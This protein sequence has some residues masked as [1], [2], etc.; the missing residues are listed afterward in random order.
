MKTIIVLLALLLLS[1]L[2]P[3]QTY[4]GQQNIISYGLMDSPENVFVSDLDGDKDMDVI[5]CS[6][7]SG[8]IVW[9]ENRDGTGDFGLKK[10]IT[11]SAST[12]STLFV[13]DMDGDNDNDILSAS[14]SQIAWY[15]NMD[16][17]GNFG[18]KRIISTTLQTGS[19]VYAADLDGD[20][21]NDVIYASRD[22]GVVAWQENLE[23]TGSFG[24][25]KII[26][27]S[28]A[29]AKCVFAKDMDGDL[30][31]DIISGAYWG[32]FIAWHENT[33]GKGN[34]ADPRIISDLADDPLDVYAAD[35]DGDGDADVLSA[36]QVDKKIAWYENLDGTGNFGTQQILSNN[37]TGANSVAACDLDKDGD[38]DVMAT[39]MNDD[40][41]MWFENLDGNGNFGEKS[42]ITSSTD[43]PSSVFAADIDGDADLD[44]IY[45]SYNDDKVAWNENFTIVILTQPQSLVICPKNTVTF[46]T[47]ANDATGFQ[48]QTNDGSGYM[49]V[50]DSYIYSGSTTNV[51]TITDADTSMS[52][53]LFRCRVYNPSGIAYTNDATLAVADYESP[54]ITSVHSN[55]SI[56]ANSE[57][58]ATLADFTHYVIA[59][60]NCDTT[61]DI[62]QTPEPGT[63]IS[64]LLNTI[65]LTVTDNFNN[66]SSVSFNI[67]VPD[68]IAPVISCTGNSVIELKNEEIV[69]IVKG[70]EFDPT[71][72][73][74]NCGIESVLNDLNNSA[75]LENQSIAP[76]TTTIKW[77]LTDKSGNLAEC[78]CNLT[79]NLNRGLTIYPNPTS[80][81]LFLEFDRNDIIN[82]RLFDV[83]GGIVL[84][85]DSP[86]QNDFLDL[87]HLPAG[88]YCIQIRC[89][90]EIINRNIVK[91]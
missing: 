47:S 40:Q 80:G 16:G 22:N 87:S 81:I 70:N 72:K 84:E 50:S 3:A 79:V 49:D 90:E 59:S 76:G 27:A 10:I 6:G 30:D 5:S 58:N 51:L 65:T 78:V 43:Y 66:K 45:S 1:S 12:I 34:F 20:G 36:S 41:V 39:S 89:N 38:N 32:D 33:D 75:T 57:C 26:S 67:E 77:T 48:W 35:M 82:V 85:K 68:N 52:G 61:L 25:Q 18:T 23:N 17:L 2:A 62:V 91:I 19:D 88:I 86:S 73:S 28:I 44:V 55:Q 60:D 29:G 21:D 56:E 8:E 9:H 7:Y 46:S 71:F 14:C 24:I 74:D 37:V 64:G 63:L 54:L 13:A 53:L 15:E 42:I 31:L 69:Y 4:F 11:S 83:N